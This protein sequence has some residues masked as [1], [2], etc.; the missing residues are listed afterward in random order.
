MA[1]R[2]S[3]SG[4][5]PLKG[6][7]WVTVK[8]AKGVLGSARGKSNLDNSLLGNH[9]LWVKIQRLA[10]LKWTRLAIQRWNTRPVQ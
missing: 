9:Q 3:R 7:V 2:S 4:L 5:S 8:T 10:F 6:A 1:L